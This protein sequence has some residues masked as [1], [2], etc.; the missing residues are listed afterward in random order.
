MEVES[1]PETSHIYMTIR[2]YQI[3]FNI[4]ANYYTKYC[5]IRITE[6]L[7]TQ[8]PLIVKYYFLHKKESDLAVNTPISYLRGPGYKQYLHKRRQTILI[9]ISFDYFILSIHLLRNL[10]M[11]LD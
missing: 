4:V 9:D 2:M 10:K 8:R 1:T 11:C 6:G 5:Q 3:K 7:S